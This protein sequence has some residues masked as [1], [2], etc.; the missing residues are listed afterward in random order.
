MLGQTRKEINLAQIRNGR[1]TTLKKDL[2]FR[3][4]TCSS[5][6]RTVVLSKGSLRRGVSTNICVKS[7]C[8]GPSIDIFDPCSSAKCNSYTSHENTQIIGYG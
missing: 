1:S 6:P 4:S 2:S 5:L 3:D 7:V 8:L